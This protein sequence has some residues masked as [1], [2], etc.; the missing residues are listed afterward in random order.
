MRGLHL[1]GLGHEH[2]ATHPQVHL[3]QEILAEIQPQK[4]SAAFNGGDC[5]V[6]KKRNNHFR[7]PGADGARV[8]DLDV[9]KAAAD[10]VFF[11]AAANDLNLGELR[12]VR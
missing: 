5:G 4:F 11:E 8:T 12:H 1:A 3:Q 10:Q 9:G 2:L 6:T 7:L